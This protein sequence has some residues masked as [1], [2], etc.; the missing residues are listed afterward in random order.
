[1][2]GPLLILV[3]WGALLSPFHRWLRRKLPLLAS[4]PVMAATAAVCL[5]IVGA[6]QAIHDP[7]RRLE[8]I[9]AQARASAP[10]VDERFEAG[11]VWRGKLRDD[12]EN[13]IAALGLGDALPG[14]S[15]Q[16][17]SL[18][19]AS[20]TGARIDGHVRVSGASMHVVG[21]VDQYAIA[22]VGDRM[23]A[24]L[25]VAQLPLGVPVTAA[26][27]PSG[28]LHTVGRGPDLELQLAPAP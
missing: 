9:V 25:P 22:F 5:S 4:A 24:G 20:I 6:L 16:D 15:G 17:A 2:L 21:L 27:D 12:T 10:A 23:L 11:D 1:V 13:Q 28:V 14:L 7:L 8:P 19:I 3:A 18:E 26:I